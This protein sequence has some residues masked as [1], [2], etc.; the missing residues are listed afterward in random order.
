MVARIGS[1][2][3]KG[4]IDGRLAIQYAVSLICVVEVRM[5]VHVLPHT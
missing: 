2:L 5:H 4:S 1:V 3:G